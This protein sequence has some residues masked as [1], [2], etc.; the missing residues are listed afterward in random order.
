MRRVRGTAL[1]GALALFLA[2][3]HGQAT[4]Q[5]GGGQAT[6]A[7][8][9]ASVTIH[10][11]AGVHSLTVDVARTAAQQERG[12]MYRTGLA[13]DDGMLFVPYPPGGGP[14]QVASFW[15]KNTPSA[16]DI[17]FIRP[18]HSIARI[19]DNAIPYDETPISSGEPVSAV[20]ELKG[21]RAA[22]LG[23]AEGDRVDWTIR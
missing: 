11:A 6:P 18:D 19:A 16:L 2:G 7:K 17:I 5:P 13:D 8:Q 22:T 15:M 3:C 23:I 9:T 1:L 14:P 12:L 20:L 21:G 4:Q 10:T